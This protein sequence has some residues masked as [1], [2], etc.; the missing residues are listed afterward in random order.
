[1]Q[2]HALTTNNFLNEASCSNKLLKQ[3]YQEHR[4]KSSYASS[5]V[6][7]ND[8]VSIKTPFFKVYYFYTGLATV[9][10]VFHDL[11]IDHAAGDD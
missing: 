6:D 2:E 3:E 4:L 9:S 10:S 8:L 1:M 5:M 11:D 7:T